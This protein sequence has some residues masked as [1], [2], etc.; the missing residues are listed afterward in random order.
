MGNCPN[1]DIIYPCFSKGADCIQR[2]SARSFG[3]VLF[4]YHG[5]SFFQQPDGEVI[6]HNTGYMAG[7]EDFLHIS[8][9]AGF[10]FNG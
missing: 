9:V 7:F 3:L 10:N 8:Q 5:N 1:G 4:V 2:N 6:E